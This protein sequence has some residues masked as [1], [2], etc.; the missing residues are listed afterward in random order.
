MMNRHIRTKIPQLDLSRPSKVLQTANDN[1]RKAKEY[2]D[3]RYQAK[4]YT[5]PVT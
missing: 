2:M 5:M 4:G 3:K 1:L